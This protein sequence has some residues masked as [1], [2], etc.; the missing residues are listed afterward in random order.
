MTTRNIEMGAEIYAVALLLWYIMCYFQ[1]LQEYNI[2]YR[3][4]CEIIY[5][6]LISFNRV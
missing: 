5:W 6:Q 2:L 3:R 1:S 4:R